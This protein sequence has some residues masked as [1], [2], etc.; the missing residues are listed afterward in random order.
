MAK[1]STLK[2]STTSQ[3]AVS[4]AHDTIHLNLLKASD[5]E[6]FVRKSR[7]LKALIK[8]RVV[9]E[10]T[11]KAPVLSGGM[12]SR[13]SNYNKSFA[14]LI[15]LTGL[16]IDSVAGLYDMSW[17]AD[18]Q[19]IHWKT[20]QLKTAGTHTSALSGVIACN[21]TMPDANTAM[22]GI[23][24]P[25]SAFL[26]CPIHDNRA[27]I[28]DI[29]N[30]INSNRMASVA[31]RV[32]LVKHDLRRESVRDHTFRRTLAMSARFV[33]EFATQ[34]PTIAHLTFVEVRN[35]I[36]RIFLWMSGSE[37]LVEYTPEF[38][39]HV[40]SWVVPLGVPMIVRLVGQF[41]TGNQLDG[42]ARLVRD[43]QERERVAGLELAQ[44][45]IDNV[46]SLQARV[47]RNRRNRN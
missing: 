34:F 47:E 44:R 1:T 17:S 9:K 30:D 28:I 29:M 27:A 22:R 46:A 3:Y 6:E 33:L 16:R 23:L 20:S 37:M 21:C 45:R 18:G 13:L 2:T 25:R 14:S 11:D 36:N 40:N 38:S 19:S 24:G 5:H 4:L 26:A 42:G 10:S 41:Y 31:S 8:R 39:V 43:A 15:S 7:M 35:A 12:Y 32:D